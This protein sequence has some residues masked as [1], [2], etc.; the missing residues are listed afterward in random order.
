M[1]AR[2][3]RC[4]RRGMKRR[5]A[6]PS[7]TGHGKTARGI[8]NL[9]GQRSSGRQPL[10]APAR[11]SDV[12]PH[13]GSSSA[14]ARMSSATSTSI[15]GLP[16]RRWLLPSY[17]RVTS[18][19]CRRK[20]VSGVTMP[21]TSPNAR[22]P[23]AFPFTES[24]RPWPSVSRSPRPSSCRPRTRPSMK[25][26]CTIATSRRLSQPP[27]ARSRNRRAGLL[28]GSASTE[29]GTETTGTE[30]VRDRPCAPHPYEF[31]GV[32]VS[33]ISAHDEVRSEHGTGGFPTRR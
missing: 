9:R 20:I 5:S 2:S 10:H 29:P 15:R 23:I 7:V 22:L 16:G 8:C 27:T 4:T 11:R 1:I 21:A 18:Y 24:R 28:T 31:T 14:I 12:Y 25:R 3:S 32:S 13:R 30:S 26:Y 17:L 6:H 33:V 19:P